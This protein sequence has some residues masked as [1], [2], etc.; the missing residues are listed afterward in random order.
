M[1]ININKWDVFGKKEQHLLFLLAV[2]G[3]SLINK[4]DDGLQTSYFTL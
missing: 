2:S 3:K 1:I 4:N